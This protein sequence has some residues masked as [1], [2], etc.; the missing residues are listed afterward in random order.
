[1]LFALHCW[2]YSFNI[3]DIS[4]AGKKWDQTFSR[5]SWCKRYTTRY[6]TT[7]PHKPIVFIVFLVFFVLLLSIVLR[8]LCLQHQVRAYYFEREEYTSSFF[9]FKKTQILVISLQFECGLKTTYNRNKSLKIYKF[10]ATYTFILF[11]T[12][13]K[14]LFVK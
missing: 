12:L 1:M 6:N 9:C 3:T 8:H 11:F 5:V 7:L 13:V 4:I 10:T 14:W 2:T